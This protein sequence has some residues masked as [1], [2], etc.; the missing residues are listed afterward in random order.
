MV[1]GRLS[2][3][4]LIKEKPHK[5]PICRERVSFFLNDLWNIVL[6][7]PYKRI[8]LLFTLT[9]RFTQPKISQFD[10]SITSQEHILRFQISIHNS[11]RMKILHC[12]DDL[13]DVESCFIYV[14]ASFEVKVPRHVS[15]LTELKAKIQFLRGLECADPFDNE[16]MLE[17]KHN[18]P[19]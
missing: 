13:T 8:E 10:V 3:Q 18:F 15:I 16:F 17:F 2:I 4:K 1:E 12:K 7:T 9:D 19:F 6:P 14:K 5:V 11:L